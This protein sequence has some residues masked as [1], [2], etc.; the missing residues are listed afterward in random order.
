MRFVGQRFAKNLCGLVGGLAMV[1]A[2]SGVAA[3]QT[4]APYVLPYSQMTTFAGPVASLTVGQACGSYVA[5]DNVGD[6]CPAKYV[7]VGD[8]PHDIR[9]DAKGNVFWIDNTAKYVV[10]KISAVTGLETIYI[11]SIAQTKVCTTGNGD[12]YGDGCI[13][14]DG[15]ANSAPPTPTIG[16]ASLPKSR[17]LGTASNGDLYWADYGGNYDHKVSAATGVMTVIAGTGTAGDVDGPVGSSLVN[18][19]RGIGVDSNT[20]N[21]YIADTANNV[22]RMVTPAGVTS[23]LTAQYAG[24]VGQ[25][26]AGC[27]VAPSPRVINATPVA[28]SQAYLC[29]PEDVQ[30]DPNGNIIIADAGDNIV[31]AIYSGTG[32]FFGIA[33][34][35]KGDVYT[36]AGF[37]VYAG[38]PAAASAYPTGGVTPTVVANTIS[39]GI[40]KIGLDSRGNVYIADAAN[41]V[42]WFL[43]IQTG[44]LRLIAG[45]A[46]AAAGAAPLGAG[47]C[48]NDSVGDGCTGPY[49]SIY[50]SAG[51]DAANQ[52]DNEGNLYLTDSEGANSPS[53]ARLRKL[54]SGLNFPAAT[55]GT[56]T[57]QTILI[58]FGVGDSQ[59]TTGAFASSNA[60]FVVGTPT[61]GPANTDLT[62]DCYVPVKFTP[63]QPGYE[64]ST[65]TIKSTLGAA[66]SY[67]L[68]GTGTIAAIAVDP[69]NAAVLTTP[70]TG[71][72]Q[73]VAV[74]GA[75]NAY[76]ADTGNNRVLKYTASTQ[77]TAVF[78]GTGA[79][80]YTGDGALATAATLK[81][82]KA[83]T[84][85]TTGNVYIADTGNNVVRRVNAAG[86]IST[87]AGAGTACSQALDTMGDG[88]PATQATFSAPSGLAADNL[89][90]IFVSDTGNNLIRQ[91]NVLGN[92][93]LLAGGAT[94]VCTANT[95]TFGDGCSGTQTKF[96]APTGLAFDA[97]GKYLIVADTG[98]NVVRRIF[99]A[100]SFSTTGTGTAVLASNIQFNGVSLIAGNGQAGGSVDASGLATLS[101]VSGPTGVAIDAAEN[102]YI[103]D[104][105]DNSIRLVSTSGTISTIVGITN[106]G[107]GGT[108]TVPGSATSAQLLTPASVAVTPLGTLFITDSGNNRV[109]TDTR[110]QVSYNF[111][112]IGI[113][114][115]GGPEN[116]AETNIGASATA[117]PTPL[118]VATG[119]NATM[120]SLTAPTGSTGCSAGEALAIGANCTLMGTF[121][122][123]TTGTFS[124]TYTETGATSA[125][126][127]PAITLI[128]TGAVLTNTNST[129]MQ[130]YPA[131]GN[132]QYGGSLTLTVTVKPALCSTIPGATCVPTG[133]VKFIVNGTASAP[134]ML[135]ATGT[136]SQTY[137]GLA[138]GMPM[139]SCTYSGDQY[140]ASSNCPNVTITISQASTTSLLSASPNNQ[141]QYPTTSCSTITAGTMKGDA[142][143][144]ASLLT[145][146]VVSNTSGIPTGTVTFLANGKSIGTGVINA[147][148]GVAMLQLSYIRDTNYN[149]VSDTTLPPGTYQLTCT[150]SGATNYA[151]SNCSAVTFTVLASP[152][153]FSLVARGCPA[154][155]LYIVGTTQP[156]EGV[157]CANGTEIIT[158]GV[159]TIATAQGSTTDATIFINATNSTAGT[160]TFSCSGLPAASICTFSPTSVPLTATTAY[161]SPQYTDVTMWTDLQPGDATSSLQKPEI[162][163]DS[164]VALAMML[165]WPV[166]LLGMI[167]LFGLRR[168]KGTLGALTLLA[169]VMVMCGTSLIF[170]GCAGPGIYKPTL[171][172]AGTYP[173]TVT[174][175]GAG[176]SQSV[177]VNFKV[178][179]PGITGQ[180]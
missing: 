173:V 132:A 54:L 127:S 17:G 177:I 71:N 152:P 179:A 157:G 85:D 176:V 113:S 89:G 154:T 48:A 96:T 171:T 9:V 107:T 109:L 58:H 23:T 45:N 93:S 76:I 180:E 3:G 114:L 94:T 60:D 103:A 2:G 134:V 34:P 102:V 67:L 166:A 49:S 159:P 133:T 16:T 78:A 172:P 104:T 33:A 38:G 13:A 145:A 164:R 1:A 165:G 42:I 19:S 24:S 121:T 31:R 75:G 50:S 142:Q 122:P 91:I 97:T 161:Q 116:F 136:A 72:A 37:N 86:I 137:T 110:T 43:D 47:T 56:A 61:C 83:V 129:I 57:T 41:N 65:L 92:V 82:P 112:T 46:G 143:C 14:T 131:T 20:G 128:G 30:V 120:F 40:R 5:L 140:Y 138:V 101:S 80:S 99:L 12:K 146:T 63:S 68:T 155:S 119:G 4:T 69:G 111:G 163:K 117:L 124:E 52:P 158:N 53:T 36:I 25:G 100:N 95:D 90:Q 150:Y 125:G 169:L 79:A 153:S 108:G 73:N 126:G 84:V 149:L 59:A 77:T 18:G 147:T 62:Y 118:Y 135:S 178:S 168:R 81:G 26:S 10:H 32:P 105:G 22:I 151:V 7:S 123:T 74:D 170:A 29:A 174:A 106:Y 6:G 15:A 144:L 87:F 141:A 70:T 98:D 139:V 167:G 66:N 44:Y 39:M 28:P 156:G 27:P 55:T 175:S 21:V 115:S 160:L 162:R 148:T 130:T 11:G 51:S 64:T 35:V 8:D 88:C